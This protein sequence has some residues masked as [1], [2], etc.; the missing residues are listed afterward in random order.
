MNTKPLYPALD[1]VRPASEMG[2]TDEQL[3][4]L[5]DIATPR[6]CHTTGEHDPK[7]F[8]ERKYVCRGQLAEVAYRLRE[9]LGLDAEPLDRGHYLQRWVGP[10][11]AVSRTGCQQ[12][13][14]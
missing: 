11:E 3:A 4:W 14:G 6:C 12:C 8:L 13:A 7:H 9:A 2:F 10:S 1:Q 5:V